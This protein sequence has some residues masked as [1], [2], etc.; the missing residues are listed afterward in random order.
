MVIDADEAALEDGVATGFQLAPVE[1]WALADA[2]RRAAEVY[3]RPDVRDRLVARAMTREV[4]WGRA[5]RRYLDPYPGLVA[6]RAVGRTDRPRR[7]PARA[8][9]RLVPDHSRAHRETA[10]R[11]SRQPV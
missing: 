4:G 7:A 1:A 9:G 11:G 8:A 10:H 3:R 5:A 6:A 2:I